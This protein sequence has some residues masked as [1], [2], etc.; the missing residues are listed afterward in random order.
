MSR[1]PKP[2]VI[3]GIEL[4]EGYRFAPTEIELME[5]YLNR[6]LQNPTYSCQMIAEKNVY[7]HLPWVLIEQ[8]PSMGIDA[9]YFFTSRKRKYQGGDR[10]DRAAGGG[11]WRA[12]GTNTPIF[13]ERKRDERK[14][15]LGYK[16]RLVFHTGPGTPCKENKTNWIMHEYC[17]KNHQ[18]A[19]TV[20]KNVMELDDWVLCKIYYNTRATATAENDEVPQLC[21]D[22]QASAQNKKRARGRGTTTA[23]SDE[24]PQELCTE[25]QAQ[26]QNKK[27][28]RGQG[29]VKGKPKTTQ[30]MLLEVPREVQGSSISELLMGKVT[31]TEEQGHGYSTCV[32]RA[33]VKT[34][35]YNSCM[36]DLVPGNST[37][38]LL[39]GKV[40]STEEQGQ[41]YSTKL[42]NGMAKI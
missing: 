13:D 40:T 42:D 38:E 3:E 6:K 22:G 30:G 27:P 5:F 4:P 1:P 31:S 37:S 2:L 15:E 32:K 12:T 16:Q 23:A 9:R 11:F 14:K 10:P 39:M 33:E 35:L 21:T 41:G 20:G 28:D 29:Q 34:E 25:G 19:K 7:D 24:V 26:A 36:P 17:N 18:I 8:T